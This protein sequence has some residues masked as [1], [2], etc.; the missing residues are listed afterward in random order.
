MKK[1][2]ALLL[3]VAM[4]VGL[5][6][7]GNPS[8]TA[9]TDSSS[10]T[11]DSS[12]SES[13]TEESSAAEEG[14]T[15]DPVNGWAEYDALIEEIRACTG[16]A[17]RA[18]LMH[19]AEDML[20]E[21]G[22][23]MPLYFYTDNY[24]Q[25]EYL[26]NVYTTPF[27]YKYFM[28]ASLDNGSDTLRLC[29]ASEPDKLDPALNSTVDGACLAIN[30]FAGLMTYNEEGQQVNDLAEDVQMSEDGLTYTVTLKD[31]LKWS[32]GDPLDANDFVYSWN[33]AANPMT[34]SDYG[35][36]FAPIKG[37]AEMTEMDDDGN[38]VNTD[39]TLDVTASEDG[40]TLT[41]NLEYPCAYFKDLLAFPT[42][43]PV[44]QASVEAADPDG[45]NPGAWALE[46]GFV[47]NGADRLGTQQLH[48]L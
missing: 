44:H 34:A 15:V 48:D 46:A 26:T 5:T 39:A 36:M 19:Q 40:K 38:L 33:R 6:A 17:K 9:S 37:Y 20:M 4:C 10:E 23:L 42:Y 31:D 16:T 18:E 21:T 22:A 2:I 41:I 3:V 11:S 1:L 12:T 24:L 8:S 45:T 47:S 35:Y 7:C 27:G 32:N 43:F 13:S 29:L 28:F 25:K 30:T 14:E